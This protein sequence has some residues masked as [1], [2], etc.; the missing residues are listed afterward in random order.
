MVTD[1][2]G[3]RL[4]LVAQSS[5]SAADF[6]VATSS[7]LTFT[8]ASA[9]ADASLTVDGVPITSA[10]NTVTGSIGGVTL[11]LLGA[12]KGTPVQLTLSPNADAI[13]EA[14]SS[15]VSAYNRLITDVNSQFAYNSATQTSGTLSAD[16]TVQGLQAQLLNATNYGSGSGADQ[17]LA[18]LGVTTN[19]DGT[20]TLDATTLATAVS[21][22][23]SAVTSFFQGAASNGF[24]A[25]LQT[26]LNAYT[27]PTEGAFTVELSSISS[28]N[29]DLT[30]QT[31]TLEL[32]L[33]TQQT[34][35]TT[36]YNTANIAL[37]QLPNEIKQ[38][39]ALL[40]PNSS[41]NS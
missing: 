29:T 15:F 13:S 28:E 23:P 35:L 24:A 2:S 41:S 11:N 21:T 12:A 31:N 37:T 40:N 14:V 19:Q 1:S 5:G 16:S 20:L 32:Y 33:A 26:S 7:G 6:S 34:A 25:A 27:D 39:D 17:S 8:Q 38:L 3:A 4:S 22:N 18:S 36:E 9:G 30:N 10:S